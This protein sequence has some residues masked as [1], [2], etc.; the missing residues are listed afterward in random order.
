MT[1]INHKVAASISKIGSAAGGWMEEQGGGEDG[2]V[3]GG[4]GGREGRAELG[5]Y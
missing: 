2:E 4:V 5:L 3:C 1:T